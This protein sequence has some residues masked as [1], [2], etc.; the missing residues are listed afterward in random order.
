VSY[1]FNYL[2]PIADCYDLFGLYRDAG[3]VDFVKN[4]IA[5]P[6]LWQ[7]A[8]CIPIAI[9]IP[10]CPPWLALNIYNSKLPGYA[11]FPIAGDGNG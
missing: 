2:Y 6:P 11:I 1:F 10:L 7:R 5:L 4:S 9:G 8:N 3:I